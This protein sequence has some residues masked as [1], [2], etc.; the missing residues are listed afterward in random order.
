[1]SDK[2]SVIVPVFNNEKY[3][4]RCLKSICENSYE[5]LEIIVVDDG[6]SD[7]SGNICDEYAKKDVRIK[8]VHQKN[9]GVS[10][11]R[12]VGIDLS[13]GKYISFVD[14][15]DVISKDFYM[16]MK[17]GL[18]SDY[19]DLCM[20]SVFHITKEN[21][22]A[23]ECN[24]FDIY[25]NEES[26]A[27]REWWYK[28]NKTY[29]LYGPCNKL[30]KADLIKKNSVS[31]PID[32]SYGEDLLF[33]FEYLNYC[34]NIRYL[35]EPQ[36]FYYKDNENSLS[37]KYQENRFLNGVRLNKCIK[38]FSLSHQL[39]SDKLLMYI[40]RRIYD[41]AYNNLFD[42][43]NEKCQLN[44]KE[45]YKNIQMIMKSPDLQQAMQIAEISDYSKFYTILINKK[46]AVFFLAIGKLRNLF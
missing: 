3:I 14:S 44:L 9:Q 31:F 33:N 5:N 25:L 17:T 23:F 11:S 39:G 18:E 8:V 40:A 28:L 38:E 32:T 15:D 21:Q 27:Q 30:Y 24:S 45:K 20:C 10:K 26:L 12:N 13:V 2:I 19:F 34:S 22:R 37:Y 42:F 6:S 29:L 7:Q 41:D 35:K 36:Y 1:M 46:M 43:F 16:L 4:E